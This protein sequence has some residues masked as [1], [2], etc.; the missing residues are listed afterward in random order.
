M[1]TDTYLNGYYSDFFWRKMHFIDNLESH[2]S[3]QKQKMED[4]LKS[5]NRT[6]K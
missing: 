3:F 2:W 6:D 4:Q 1:K 5:D